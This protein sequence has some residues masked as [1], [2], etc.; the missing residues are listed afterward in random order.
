MVTADHVT[1]P[2]ARTAH[3]DIS[4]VA[5]KYRG[6]V[7]KENV[8]FLESFTPA[9]L[10]TEGFRMEAVGAGYSS[11]RESIGL[12]VESLVFDN[13]GKVVGGFEAGGVKSTRQLRKELNLRIL[14]S[15]K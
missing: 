13:K 4:S 5:V 8:S 11:I 14:E 7:V 3:G 9:G 15:I 10:L 2:S 12:D 1:I 6:S